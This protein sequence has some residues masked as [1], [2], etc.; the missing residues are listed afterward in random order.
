MNVYALDDI[1][2]DYLTRGVLVRRFLAWLVDLLLIALL[3]GTLWWLL[4]FFGF[5]T[6]GLGMGALAILPFVPFLYHFLSLV[7]RNAATPGQQA[8]GLTVRRNDDLD[9]PT[10]LQALVYVLLFYLTFAT[11]GLLFLVALFT[12]RH[13]TLH[14]IFSGL[15]VI[16]FGA[17]EA[18]TGPRGI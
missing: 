11:T 9:L 13:R 2:A 17:L 4:V 3:A 6:F 14:D 16:R 15:V 1:T 18:L 10:P 7:G 8:F 12:E 5:L